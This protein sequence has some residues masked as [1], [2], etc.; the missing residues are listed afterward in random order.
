[1]NEAET[2]V[3]PRFDRYPPIRGGGTS[4]QSNLYSYFPPTP[5]DGPTQQHWLLYT[6]VQ[7]I[8]EFVCIILLLA[9]KYER[10]Y[11]MILTTLVLIL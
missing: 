2:F 6:R 9:S 10:M 1:M 7:Y 4:N 5:Y 8:Y 11:I 3:T